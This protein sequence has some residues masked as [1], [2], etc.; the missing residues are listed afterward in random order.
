MDNVNN[1]SVSALS[2]K[3]DPKKQSIME[4]V[5]GLP[6]DTKPIAARIYMGPGGIS[7]N[8]PLSLY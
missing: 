7:H 8:K 1:H 3:G 2:Q 5:P 4:Y 6:Q